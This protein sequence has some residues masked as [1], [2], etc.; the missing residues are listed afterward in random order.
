MTVHVDERKFAGYVLIKNLPMNANLFRYHINQ[1]TTL[2]LLLK[3]RIKS[4]PLN[5]LQTATLRVHF[6]STEG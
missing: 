3:V 5:W 2:N 1:N 6:A 4:N